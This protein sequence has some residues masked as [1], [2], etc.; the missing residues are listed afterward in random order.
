MYARRYGFAALAAGSFLVAD[1]AFKTLIVPAHVQLL[2]PRTAGVAL[3][4]DLYL[5]A[6]AAVLSGFLIFVVWL[7]R[8]VE[9]WRMASA[10]GDPSEAAIRHAAL[11]AQRFPQRL[12]VAWACEWVLLFASVTAW[13][14]TRS[15]L[16]SG[17]FLCA[18]A[19]GSLPLATELSSRGLGMGG[20]LHAAVL[21]L[22]G[23]LEIDS[24]P[25]RGTLL[26][27]KFPESAVAPAP[28]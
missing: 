20:A 13:G 9:R 5:R 18:M 28:R 27:M 8:D 7:A 17:F 14:G 15:P 23:A 22:G 3:R 11:A 6:A 21:S 1:V 12:A 2:G 16:A 4:L 19:G 26:S 10:A 25:G 24:E